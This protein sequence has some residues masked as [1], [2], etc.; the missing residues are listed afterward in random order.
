MKRKN[1]F[2]LITVFII[3]LTA[4][5]TIYSVLKQEKDNISKN[6]YRT[7]ESSQIQYKTEY[8]VNNN[9]I[10]YII[11]TI[12]NVD[13]CSENIENTKKEIDKNNNLNIY[14]DIKYSCGGCATLVKT[15]EIP[16]D[17]SANINEIK[18]YYKIVSEEECNLDVVKKPI[19]YIYPTKEIDLS[20]KL[21]NNK[22]LTTSYPKYNNRWNIHV[23]T[24]GNIYDYNT[25]RNYY[26]LY[27]EAHDNTH[28]NMNEGFVIEGK[29]T[30]K[31][32]EEKLE[33][34]GLNEKETNEFIIYW[35]DKLESN[36]YNFIRFRNT[37]EAN[38]YMPL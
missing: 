37:E 12:P 18:A 19:I 3:V 4:S 36:K 29:D 30:V 23:D 5:I 9:N 13:E 7:F 6:K 20:I 28:I 11:F 33:Y 27:W 34:L 32:L 14:F 38:E 16:I 17:D 26:A 21:K 8:K 10:K 15:F 25:K 24:N 35:I 1:L 31:F 22:K 2:I